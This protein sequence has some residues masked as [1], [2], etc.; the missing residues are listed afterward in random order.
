MTLPQSHGANSPDALH[1][2]HQISRSRSTSHT[3]LI[4]TPTSMESV[5]PTLVGASQL[6]PIPP[7]LQIHLP[8]R[9][10][11]EA[12]SHVAAVQPQLQGLIHGGISS[13]GP[14]TH[15]RSRAA[16][17]TTIYSYASQTHI[18]PINLPAR[19]PTIKYPRP[20]DLS[21]THT[22]TNQGGQS[23]VRAPGLLKQ[24][25]LSPPNPWV[26]PP[27]TRRA[28]PLS[29]TSATLLLSR[30]TETSDKYKTRRE[31]GTEVKP[32]GIKYKFLR[33]DPLELVYNIRTSTWRCDFRSCLLLP[34]DLLFHPPTSLSPRLSSTTIYSPNS[35]LNNLTTTPVSTFNS[36]LWRSLD[37]QLED[38]ETSNFETTITNPPL[39][40]DGRRML[41]K[42]PRWK[43]DVKLLWRRSG[44]GRDNSVVERGV[45]IPGKVWVQRA[46]V[47][48]WGW[49]WVEMV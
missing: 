10:T 36:S 49:I 47:G 5:D 17:N 42:L 34:S 29:S 11:G 30:E 25:N 20:S 48:W 16:T 40:V 32:T 2:P 22:N 23:H 3:T 44:G 26:L 21:Q 8:Q 6:P 15:Q 38:S 46:V 24:Y 1:T 27:P 14:S 31:R 33:D 37:Q 7:S 39:L 4:G 9:Q 35:N 28:R 13:A 41:V 43:R 45:K 18:Q 19:T 12:S